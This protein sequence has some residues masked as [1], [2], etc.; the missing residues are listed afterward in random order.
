MLKEST[1]ST[2]NKRVDFNAENMFMT[3]DQC[4]GDEALTCSSHSQT[5]PLVN[6]MM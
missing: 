2:F 6:I 1:V 4:Q 5:D 3:E